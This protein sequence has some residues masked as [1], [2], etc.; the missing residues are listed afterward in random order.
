[1]TAPMIQA[2]GPLA[3]LPV[4]LETRFVRAADN[5]PTE[6]LVRMYV[7]DIHV[8]THEPGLTAAETEQGGIFVKASGEARPGAWRALAGRFGPQRAAWIARTLALPTPAPTR[9]GSWTRAPRVRVLPDRWLV[10]GYVSGQQVLSQWGAPIPDEI[11]VGPDP[12]ARAAAPAGGLAADDGMLWLVDFDRA[13]DKG[14]AV[15][16]PLPVSAQGGLHRLVVVGVKTAYPGDDP[17][18]RLRQLFDAHHYTRGLAFVPEGTPT[19][20]TES[21]PSG[22][23]SADPGYADSYAVEVAGALPPDNSSGTRAARALGLAPDDFAHVAHAATGDLDRPRRAMNTVLWPA[24]LGYFLDQL[25]A[26]VDDTTL[27]NVRT[28]FVERVRAAGPLPVLRVGPQPYGLLPVTSL[29]HWQPH[30]LPELR[31]LADFLRRS[32]VLWQDSTRWVPRTSTGRVDADPGQDLL[33]AL[34]VQPVSVGVRTRAV[35]GGGYAAALWRY[36]RKPLGPQWQARQA[37]LA[38]A[39]LA[40]LGLTW[41]PRLAGASSATEWYDWTG[42]LVQAQP[43]SEHAALIQD[44]LSWLIGRGA[45]D[46]TAAPGYRRVRDDRGSWIAGL[47]APRPLLYLLARHGYL[48]EY[49]TAAAGLLAAGPPG[50]SRADRAEPEVVDVDQAT[51]ADTDPAPRTQTVWDLLDRTL[52]ATPVQP[53]PSGPAGRYLDDHDAGTLDQFR[54]AMAELAALPSAQLERLLLETLDLCSH[55]LDAWL[56]SLAG[57]RLEQLRRNGVGTTLLGGY[58]WLENVLPAAGTASAG[59]LLAPSPVHATTAAILAS[60]Q[61]SGARMGDRTLAID[62]SSQR[63]RLAQWLLDGVRQGQPLGALLGYRFERALHEGAG[64]PAIA[65]DPVIAAFRAFV[66]TPGGAPTQAGTHEV[67]PAAGVV[68]GLA[69]QREW[70][71]L[72]RDQSPWGTGRWPA[73]AEPYRPAVLAALRVLDDAVDAVADLLLAE[74][75]HQMAQGNP[76]RA[77]P[78][79]D[80]LAGGTTS[81]PEPDVS[82]TPQSGRAF[83]QR[84][85]VLLPAPAQPPT[86]PRASAEPRLDAWAGQ[87]LP[88]PANVRLR[89]RW[90]DAASGTTL[91]EVTLSLADLQPALS[92]LDVVYAADSPDSAGE[93]GQ[94]IGYQLARARPQQVPAGARLELLTD[95]AAEWTADIVSLAELAEL[96]RAARELFGGARPLSGNDLRLPESGAVVTVA[97]AELTARARAAV[98]ALTAAKTALDQATDSETTRAALLGAAAFGVPGAIPASA[99]GDDPTTLA[100]LRVQVATA[101]GEVARRLAAAP[102]ATAPVLTAAEATA[103]LRSVFGQSFPVLPTFTL[104]GATD[105]GRFDLTFARSDELLDRDPGNAARWLEQ[106]GHVRDGVRRLADALAYAE[107][108]ALTGTTATGDQPTFRLAQLPVQAGDRW[109]G[110]PFASGITGPTGRLALV[111]HIPGT[112]TVNPADPIAGLLIDEWTEVVPDTT[113][114]AAI[115][116]HHDQP[117]ACAPQ[118]V[119]LAIPPDGRLDWDADTLVAVVSQALDLAKF[120]AVDPDALAGAG[121]FLPALYFALNLRGTTVATDFKHGTG[122]ALG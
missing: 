52:P 60:G 104:V 102:A 34:S 30:D 49:A 53:A 94:R 19:N 70:A 20:V 37:E 115:A 122:I 91:T 55:R 105:P 110:L 25:M 6:L 119:L 92:P 35:L 90:H 22:H 43:I 79:L 64:P 36:L 108:L 41:K 100:T 54:A 69:L 76:A 32:R 45:A 44:Y 7:D 58:G 109:I 13:V 28:H 101:A 112:G 74:S 27:H 46:V 114:T 72:N 89:A 65:A 95:R 33:T 75:V 29:D 39:A 82:R 1:M 31:G 59:H 26:D 40:R 10:R 120:R 86:R 14:M 62:L 68:D 48:L 97:D 50:V 96:A 78:A 23:T 106:L 113:R 117:D 4:R 66:P 57:A 15:R 71:A 87:L 11:G 18:T 24:T 56:T 12:A 17:Q 121:Q 42:P 93:L 81:A 118:A 111:A 47:P 16:I 51:G 38:Q 73:V 2:N 107:A 8:D 21:G 61:L 3:L 5:T 63:V 9:T 88:A 84:L 80:A 77:A 103:A 98:T 99:T 116:F 83:P 85:A 67:V